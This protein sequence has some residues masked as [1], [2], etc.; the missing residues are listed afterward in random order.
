VKQFDPRTGMEL[1]DRQDCLRLLGQHQRGVG[2][3][4]LIEG[5]R[6][7]IV[8]VNYAMVED[9]IVFRT[10]PGTKLD[11]ADRG[12]NVAF[13]IDHIDDATL[14]GWSVVVR[15]RAEVVRSKQDLF[16]LRATALLPYAPAEKQTWVV[17]EPDEISGRRVPVG[18]G[19]VL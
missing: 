17:I 15:G 10:G 19:F 2:R 18:A 12:G 1:V 8:V 5:S 13:E 7:T 6:P 4:A 16:A 9:R 11:V 3:L 14:S